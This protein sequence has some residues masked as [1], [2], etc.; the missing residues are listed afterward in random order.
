ML[1]RH[2]FETFS[3]RATSW[4]QRWDPWECMWVH[5]WLSVCGS[6]GYMGNAR[7]GKNLAWIFWIAS[8]QYWIRAKG[9]IYHIIMQSLGWARALRP[10]GLLLVTQWLC[11]RYLAERDDENTASRLIARQLS[12]ES[13]KQ[14]AGTLGSY[15][16][17][18]GH[19]GQ[20]G[21]RPWP[22]GSNFMWGSGTGRWAGVWNHGGRWG[23]MGS[24]SG[25][26]GGWGIWGPWGNM[27]VREGSWGWLRGHGG[28]WGVT[29]SQFYVEQRCEVCQTDPQL[30]AWQGSPRLGLPPVARS[31][32]CK[33]ALLQCR[34]EPLP[35][36][37]PMHSVQL[38]CPDAGIIPLTS[39]GSRSSFL[40]TWGVM[41]L[42]LEKDSYSPVHRHLTICLTSYYG[43]NS[44]NPQPQSIGL[45][46]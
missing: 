42:Y 20:A 13:A 41:L 46:W 22:E 6:P 14:K 23:M 38:S 15:C 33:R 10:P 29:G 37:F 2:F 19:L 8:S 12:P 32:T 39:T 31:P 40:Q 27:G 9:E 11:V 18:C 3:T 30:A 21:L 25:T 16:W 28:G 43:L 26:W 35:H 5:L 34:Q 1:G 36:A 45:R 7:I 17:R 24:V 44:D 4:L